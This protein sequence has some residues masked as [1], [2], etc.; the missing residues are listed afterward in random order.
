MAIDNIRLVA[1]RPDDPVSMRRFVA[2]MNQSAGQLHGMTRKLSAGSVFGLLS[3]QDP[4][5]VDITGGSA[6]LDFL[7]VGAGTVPGGPQP[8]IADANELHTC[9]NYAEVN[10]ALNAIGATLNS[11]LGVLRTFGFI[12]T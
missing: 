5:A 3:M 4:N 12:E 11:V 2:A 6:R 10:A 8:A 9:W 1:A 7:G